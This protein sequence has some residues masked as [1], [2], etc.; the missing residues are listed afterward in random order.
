[1][2]TLVYKIFGSVDAI[3]DLGRPGVFGSESVVDRK[4]CKLEGVG[5]LSEL[6]ILAARC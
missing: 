1:M 3:M 6:S 2:F 4:R 5:V